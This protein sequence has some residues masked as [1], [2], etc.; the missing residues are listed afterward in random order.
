[1]LQPSGSDAD[2]AGAVVVGAVVAGV[3]VAAGAVRACSLRSVARYRL[4]AACP[5]EVPF[6]A[7]ALRP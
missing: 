1:M 7:P 3:G 4:P 6:R 2:G 5:F